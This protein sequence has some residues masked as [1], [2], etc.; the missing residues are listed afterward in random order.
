MLNSDCEKRIRILERKLARSEENRV[1]IEEALESHIRAL[2]VGVEE[3]VKSHEIIKTSEAKFKQLALYDALTNLPS[4]ILF[5]EKLERSIMHAKSSRSPLAVLFIDLDNF[6]CVNDTFG[7]QAGDAV[8]QESSLRLLSCVRETDTVSRLAG[9]EFSV[10]L[11][12]FSNRTDIEVIADRIVST[13]IRPLRINSQLLA[14]GASIGISLFPSD[15]KT[16]DELL[17]KADL[18]MYDAKKRAGNA[19][20]FYSG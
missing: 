10:I 5:F 7:H 19:W 15:G 14:V 11:E 6:K 8:L 1:L 4:R 20:Q 9:D 17:K 12:M 16:P 3:L 13:L 2:R 18:A